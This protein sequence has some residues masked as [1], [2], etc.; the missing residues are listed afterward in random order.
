MKPEIGNIDVALAATFI[1]LSIFVRYWLDEKGKPRHVVYILWWAFALMAV[2]IELLTVPLVND[3]IHW[4]TKCWAV[5]HGEVNGSL[6]L[7]HLLFRPYLWIGLGPS[8]TVFVGR[9]TMA[10]AAVLCALVISCVASRFDLTNRV[11]PIIGAISLIALAHNVEMVSL[12]AEYFALIFM[13]AGTWALLSTP[14]AQKSATFIIFGFM[15]FALAETTSLRQALMLPAAFVAVAVDPGELSRARALALGLVGTVIGLAPPVIYIWLKESFEA[16]YYRNFIWPREAGW[17]NVPAD[18]R[19]PY[20]LLVFGALGCLSL[21]LERRK[22]PNSKRLVVLWCFATLTIVFMPIPF[23]HPAGLWYALSFISAGAL[24]ARFLTPGPNQKIWC[25]I[26]LAVLGFVHVIRPI[27]LLMNPKFI[28]SR[29]AEQRSQFRLID[30]L[31]EVSNNDMVLCVAPYHPITSPNGWEMW[32]GWNYAFVWKPDLS[33][34]VAPRLEEILRS[35]R[36][37]VIA[38]DPWPFRSGEANILAHAVDRGLLKNEN[39]DRVVASLA[40]NYRLVQWR[41]PL[42]VHLFG[43]GMFLVWRDIELDERV[44]PVGWKIVVGWRDGKPPAPK[45]NKTIDNGI[46]AK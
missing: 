10:V 37:R 20:L 1:L 27:G 43:A 18:F 31:K 21:L 42:P 16:V 8:A 45:S 3:E 13:L 17:L 30:W 25:A 34:Q 22:L 14:G 2:G 15:A 26:L 24:A 38:W 4:L 23:S 11:G 9:V 44:T 40:N 28:G 39:A 12:K 33:R 29:F 5:Q 7:R 35:G 36:P 32:I 19:I 6:P 46:S 41:G